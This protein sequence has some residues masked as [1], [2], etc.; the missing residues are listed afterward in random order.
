[1]FEV[2]I[3]DISGKITLKAPSD[4]LMGGSFY[5]SKSQ[6]YY[7]EPNPSWLSKGQHLNLRTPSHTSDKA[8]KRGI[9]PDFETQADITRSS[10][11]KSQK[12]L[13]LKERNKKTPL[14]PK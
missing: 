3:N 1:M 5:I 13:V 4:S 2:T 12:E 9:H 6:F 11:Q 8:Q 14:K 7:F 10:V